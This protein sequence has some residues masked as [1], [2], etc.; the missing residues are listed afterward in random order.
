MQEMK[1]R[2]L[3]V[4]ALFAAS[5]VWA[6]GQLSAQAPPDFLAEFDGQFN[7]SA[8]KLVALA[9]AMPAEAYDWAPME[10]VASVAEVYMHIARYN[11]FYPETAMGVESPMG[12]AEY[13]RWEDEVR[14]KDQ[15]VEILAE[16]MEHV[17]SVA[18]GMS[19]EDLNE[20]TRLYGRNVGQWAVLLQLVTHMN[21]H[22]GQSIAYARMNQV[23]PP[24]SR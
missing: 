16:S 24:W 7:A 8:G 17:R 9:K 3:P 13:D 6:S 20:I 1:M 21:E 18:A 23:V 22:L 12:R 15:A 5:V 14:D 11:Y 2:T 19:A 4:T 10:G